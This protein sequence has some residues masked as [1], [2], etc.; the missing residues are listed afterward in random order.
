MHSHYKVNIS[1]I[2]KIKLYEKIVTTYKDHFY[3]LLYV[4]FIYRLEYG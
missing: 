1:I 3:V 2:N 4:S